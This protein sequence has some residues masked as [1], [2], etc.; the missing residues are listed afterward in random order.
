MKTITLDNICDPQGDARRIFLKWNYVSQNGFTLDN[1]DV[2]ERAWFHYHSALRKGKLQ[3]QA[4]GSHDLP[5]NV[6]ITYDD[7]SRQLRG[8][9]PQKLISALQF[10]WKTGEEW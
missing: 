1:Q 6:I 4:D 3:E 5:G 8:S 10:W 9:S 7:S 2:V